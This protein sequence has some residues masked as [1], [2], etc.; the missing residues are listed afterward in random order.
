MAQWASWCAQIEV[1]R[2]LLRQRI[3]QL[4]GELD[5]L[6][7]QRGTQR[8]ARRRR[9]V[10]QGAIVGYTNVGKSSLLRALSRATLRVKWDVC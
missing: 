2:R 9:P 8:K 7:R 4:R 5:E 10:S 3:R 1:D 6:A